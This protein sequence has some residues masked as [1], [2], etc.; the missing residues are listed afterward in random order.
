MA[1]ERVKLEVV[2]PEQAVLAEEVE[3]VVLPGESGQMGVL[4]GHL[5]LLSTL[6]IGEMVVYNDGEKR[7]FVIEGGLVEVLD[8]HISVLTKSC[9]GIDEIDIEHAREELKEAETEIKRLEEKAESDEGEDELLEKYRES[10]KR[11][12]TRLLVADS[13]D[14]EH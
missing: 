8:D 4:P 14:S 1:K 13:D 7:N 5:P 11:A 2:T 10:L 9:Q 12:R 3:E 6:S